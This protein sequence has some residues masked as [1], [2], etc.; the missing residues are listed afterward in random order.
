MRIETRTLQVVVAI[1]SLV[2]IAAGGTGVILGPGFFGGHAVASADL[3]GHFRYLSGLLLGIG[4][5]YLSAVPKIEQ[6]RQRFLL[7][8]GLVVLGGLGRLLSVLLRGAASQ[9][10]LFALAME[11][12]VAPVLMFWQLCIARQ[13]IP[14]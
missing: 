1:G 7:L 9:T 10:M 13:T 11:L 2:P 12:V 4:L 8:T 6:R 14:D 5:A 3:D